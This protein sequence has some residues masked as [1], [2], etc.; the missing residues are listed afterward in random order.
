MEH[1]RLFYQKL[2]DVEQTDGEAQEWFFNKITRILSQTER[3]R[4]EGPITDLELEAAIKKMNLN[5]SPG[6]DGLPVE[7]YKSFWPFLKDDLRALLNDS[8]DHGNLSMS[9][10]NAS[11]RLLYKKGERTLL[12]NWRPISLLNTDYKLLSTILAMRLK[13]LLPKVIN[14]DQTCGVPGRTIFENLF[15]LRDITQEAMINNSNLI[16]VN[17]DQEKAFDKIDRTFPFK[18]MAKMNFGPS[19]IHWIKVLYEHANCNIVNNG[20]TF[21]AVTLYRGVRQGCP[22]SPLLYIIVAE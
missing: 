13:P 7:F 5:K 9:Q 16:M 17:L 18:S 21:D 11:L 1:A 12:K 8:Y 2:Y 3:C 22:L 6:S 15:R 19:F 10:I 4:A 14:E 20:W